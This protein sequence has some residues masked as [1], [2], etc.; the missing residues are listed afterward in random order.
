MA[1]N[2]RNEGGRRGG[3][4]RWAMWGGAA[5]LL[6][7]P[8]VA[9]Q[10]GNNGVNWTGSDFVVFGAMLLL[11]CGTFELGA[12]LSRD[13][14]YRA[15]FGIAVAAGFLLTWVNLAVGIIGDG[16]DPA[17]LVFFGVLLVGAI[18]ACVARFKSKGMVRALMA[19]AIA[20][21]LAGAVAL[22]QGSIEGV[23]LS[24]CFVVA[25]LVSAAL[26]RKAAP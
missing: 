16:N 8:A 21:A 14:A 13:R 3:L 1:A 5:A 10:V 26:F 24:A 22:A 6:L 20:Q 2:M 19:T 18:G 11:A 12:W 9:M 15:A 4:W 17:N 7:L 23:G 25:W